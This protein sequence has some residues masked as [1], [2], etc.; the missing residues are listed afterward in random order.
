MRSVRILLAAMLCT[1][2]V[3]A[4]ESPAQQVTVSTPYHALN[5]S[6]FENIGTSWGL[7]GNNWFLNVNGSPMQ[8]APQ[9][10]GFDPSAG[11]NTGWSFGGNGFNG[12]FNLAGAQG[13]RQSFTSQTPSVTL[14]NGQ[15]GWIS[16]SSQS[17]F[18]IGY[19]PVVG[20]IP[21]VPAPY[22]PQTYPGSPMAPMFQPATQGNHRVQAMLQ[23]LANQDQSDGSERA[24]QPA[25]AAP[26]P[27]P[28][29]PPPAPAGDGL[30][31]VGA[32]TA[33]AAA[34]PDRAA[35]QLAAAQSSSA[36]RAVPSVAE[37]RRLHQLEQNSEDDE[38][39]VLFERGQTAEEGGKLGAAKVY[40]QMAAQRAQGTL[41]DQIQARLNALRSSGN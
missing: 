36:G 38:A 22:L 11:V 27:A 23:Q 29:Q 6:F 15:T 25:A 7:R 13:Y 21:M 17:P 5:D 2:S 24:W 30:D 31:L 14:M 9:F 40:Y 19:I 10:G 41:G 16:D 39:K 1:L 34:S 33:S 26:R 20:G 28:A 3:A 32:G 12:F 18:V 4:S 8:A 35:Q 37:A